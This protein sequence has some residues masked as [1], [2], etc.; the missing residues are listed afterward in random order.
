MN[1][2]RV[3]KWGRPRA[4]KYYKK[5]REK[6][7]AHMKEYYKNNKDEFAKRRRKY[8]EENKDEIFAGQK[9]YFQEHKKEIYAQRIRLTTQKRTT[10]IEK[11]G[12]KCTRCGFTDIRALNIDHIN[13][14]GAKE[15]IGY[16]NRM[17]YDKLL[18]MTD[19]ELFSRYQVLCANCNSIKRL[20]KLEQYK[21][22]NAN[23]K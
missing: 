12:G 9:K 6:A 2:V 13:D 23:L 16:N 10:I 3:Q 19:E 15:R 5:H 22:Y 18:K 17:F 4:Q 11:L 7:I 20:E 8:Y 14:D 21:E 1:K